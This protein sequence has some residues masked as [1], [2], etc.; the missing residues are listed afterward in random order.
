MG[1]DWLDDLY[2]NSW[3]DDIVS[4]VSDDIL[5]GGL[6]SILGS[7]APEATTGGGDSFWDNLFSAD[8]MSASLPG[9]ITAIA[10]YNRPDAPMSFG[11]TEE[12]F[13]AN[14]DQLSDIAAA[15]REARLQAAEIA[16]AAMKEA[17][18]IKAAAQIK[19]AKMGL[20]GNLAAIKEKAL[21]DKVSLRVQ[22]K[23]GRPELQTQVVDA[24]ARN[25]L[26]TG[27][28]AQEGQAHSG[29]VLSSFRR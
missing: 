13:Y 5:G 2:S 7:G 21:A 1:W 12:G 20:S 4:V 23:R 9:I 28:M 19:Q 10:A 24:I 14:L 15:D 16:A 27:R 6:G 18:A 17:A 22:G 29:S 8:T 25:K 11:S 3:L 26:A